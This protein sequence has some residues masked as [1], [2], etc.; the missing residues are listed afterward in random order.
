MGEASGQN[1][2]GTE[3]TGPVLL[4]KAGGG[5]DFRYPPVTLAEPGQ[6]HSKTK[7]WDASRRP[8][9]AWRQNLDQ[10]LSP[11]C[12]SLSSSPGGKEQKGKKHSHRQFEVHLI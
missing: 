2:E 12:G 4:L 8:V 10:T 5:H 9:R 1:E 11:S 3:G 7:G 6:Q